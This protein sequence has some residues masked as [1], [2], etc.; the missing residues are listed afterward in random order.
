MKYLLIFGSLLR[1][2]HRRSVFKQMLIGGLYSGFILGGAVAMAQTASSR[3]ASMIVPYPAGGPADVTARHI[4]PVMRQSL[5]YGFVIENLAGASGAIAVEK[6]LNAPK[7]GRSVLFADPSS[8][9]LAPLALAAV[10]HRPDQLRLVG[11]ASRTPLILVSGMQ[12]DAASLLESLGGV[13]KPSLATVNYGSFGPGS[14]PHLAAEDFAARTRLP[15]THVPYKGAAPLVQDLIGGQV[16]LAFL[17]VG[18][19]TVELIR[20]KKLKALAVA[21]EQRVARLPD[22]PTVTEVIGGKD[23]S[24]E[25]WGGIF[26]SKGVPDEIARRLNQSVEEALR[27]PEYRRQTELSGASPGQAMNLSQLDQFYAAQAQHYKRIADAIG[28]IAQ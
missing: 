20:Q 25:I 11:M 21:S 24:F 2:A 10:R 8:V 18:G 15:M 13:R 27:D 19:N 4:E 12:F 22:I 26:V 6:L 17:P 14:L 1:C 3:M 7:D 28:L 23:F 16:Q 5:G 9:I